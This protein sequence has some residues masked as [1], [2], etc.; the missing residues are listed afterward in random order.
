MQLSSDTEELPAPAYGG[1]LRYWFKG[2]MIFGV[3]VAG[4][5]RRPPSGE[6]DVWV[7]APRLAEVTS[8]SEAAIRDALKKGFAAT[9]SGVTDCIVR[10]K[11]PEAAT[12]LVSLIRGWVAPPKPKAAPAAQ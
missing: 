2:R 5:R 3:N 7:P 11:S 4:G 12:N 9:E 6:L 10:L 1:S 8:V